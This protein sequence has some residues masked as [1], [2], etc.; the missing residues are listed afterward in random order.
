MCLC[1]NAHTTHYIGAKKLRREP[2]RYLCI[3]RTAH[4]IRWFAIGMLL[5]ATQS[6][7]R[8]SAWRRSN[9]ISIR[10]VGCSREKLRL[11]VRHGCMARHTAKFAS[12]RRRESSQPMNNARSNRLSDIIF[13]PASRVICVFSARAFLFVTLSRHSRCGE[14]HRKARLDFPSASVMPAISADIYHRCMR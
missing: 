11:R 3:H 5:K 9:A 1:A 12:T 8:Y 6:E 7:Q 2:C 10:T 4:E 14:L 13:L